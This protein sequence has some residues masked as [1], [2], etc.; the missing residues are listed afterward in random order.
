VAYCTQTDIEKTLPAVRLAELTDDV[1]GTTT[2]TTNLDEQIAFADALIDAHLRGKHDVPYTVVPVLVRR[3]SVAFTI[4][5]LFER[6]TDLQIPDTFTRLLD[7]AKE[8][9]GMVQEGSL[10]IND[11]SSEANTA[12]YYAR[13][14]TSES[15]IFTVEDDES[16]TLD[17][18][19]SKS[20]IRPC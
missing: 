12:G 14:K 20:R 11:P 5:N 16:G 1:N 7:R 17:Q 6:R 15:R 3:W 9:I 19:F 4:Q 8:E 18:Y 13:N 10:M 2:D